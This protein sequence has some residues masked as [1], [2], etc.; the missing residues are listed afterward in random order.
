MYPAAQWLTLLWSAIDMQLSNYGQVPVAKAQPVGEID[1]RLKDQ[2]TAPSKNGHRQAPDKF[3]GI[4]VKAVWR[5]RTPCS[6]QG[7]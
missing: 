5:V 6:G 2:T 4:R 7:L 3:T 1:L